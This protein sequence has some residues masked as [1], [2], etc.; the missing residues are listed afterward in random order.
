[1]KRTIAID[2]WNQTTIEEVAFTLRTGGG[3]ESNDATQKVLI[4]F[5]DE[6]SDADG[7]EI[8]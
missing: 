5:D 8:F 3:G 7:E 6:E 2:M 1:M 4:A